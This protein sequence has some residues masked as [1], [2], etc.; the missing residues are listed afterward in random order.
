MSDI[1]LPENLVKSM[2]ELTPCVVSTVEGDKPYSTFITWL[3]AIDDET[4]RM[5]VSADAKTTNNIRNNPNVSIEVFDKDVAMSI[6]GTANI[7]QDEIPTIPFPVS[8]I[9]IKVNGVRNNL[10]PGGTITGKIPFV[11]TGDIEKAE[12]LDNMVLEALKV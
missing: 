5:A 8:V 6:T 1:K 7:I 11:H 9:E 2:E 10:F 12:E 4:L 3:I